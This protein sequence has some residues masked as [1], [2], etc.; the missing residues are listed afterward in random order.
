MAC[1]AQ[2][3]FARQG[4]DI[5]QDKR[6]QLMEE[7]R[8]VAD[9]VLAGAGA[10]EHAAAQ[11]RRT[12]ALAEAWDGPEAVWSAGLAT[13]SEL[14]LRARAKTV[15]GV[16]FAEIEFDPVARP[17]TGRGYSLAGTSPRIDS[18][19]EQY[20]TLTELLLDLAAHELRLR[21]LVD[22][23][24][25][26]TRRVNALE[27]VVIPRLEEVRTAIQSILDERERQHIFRL[28]R[29]AARREARRRTRTP[30]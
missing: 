5:L 14:S 24:A 4:R 28:R 17:R 10:V 25:K 19:A 22:E 6:D 13:R 7:F 9:V 11:G 2:I 12:L 29:F 21:R 15:M 27:W 18:V 1:R 23:I 8:N 26:T 30:A 16:R 3:R 20:E